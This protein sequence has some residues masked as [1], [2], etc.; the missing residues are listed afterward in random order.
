MSN[1]AVCCWVVVSR[2]VMVQGLVVGRYTPPLL[3]PLGS[4]LLS[5]V[6]AI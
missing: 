4:E 6:D 5:T 1:V 2:E 3:G